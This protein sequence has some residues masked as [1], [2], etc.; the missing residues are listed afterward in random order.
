[1]TVLVLGGIFFFVDHD[2]GISCSPQFAPWAN[3]GEIIAS[4]GN[5]L[6]GAALSL[7]GLLGLYFLV[8]KQGPKLQLRGIAPALMFFFVAWAAI[9]ITWSIDP[10]LTAHRVAV[11]CFYFLGALGI[12]RQLSDR[13]LAVAALAITTVYLAVGIAAELALGTFRPWASDYRFSGTVHPNFQGLHLMILCLAAFLLAQSNPSEGRRKWFIILFVI[14]FVFLLLTKSR[15]SLG[16][17]MLAISVLWFLKTTSFYRTLSAAGILFCICATL[18]ICSLSGV[19]EKDAFSRVLTLGRQDNSEELT[20]RL[21]IWNELMQYADRRPMT[22]YGYESFWTAENIEDLSEPLGWRFRQAHCGYIDAVLSAGLIGGACLL[23]VVIIGIYKAA[24]RFRETKHICCGITL[25]MLIFGLADAIL[26][27]GM[28][29]GNFVTLLAGCGIIQLLCLI[30]QS[31][32][33]RAIDA[34]MENDSI[35]ASVVNSTTNVA[36]PMGCSPWA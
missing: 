5:T 17:F 27:S 34:A 19:N 9:S 31:D 35:T 1:M 8:D 23:M 21:P 33:H 18:L 20:G 32:S 3:S 2:L 13:D 24:G 14:G 28:V 15:T 10:P 16:G 26:E 4:G 11:L 30:P 7:I 6:K 12:A 36:K 25:G 22:G 29:G